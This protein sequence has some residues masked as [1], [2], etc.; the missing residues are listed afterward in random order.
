MQGDENNLE[1]SRDG[2]IL[3]VIAGRGSDRQIYTRAL[4][5]R[6]FR[7]VP[8][9]AGLEDLSLAVSPD[10][11]WV[12]FYRAGA[13][14]KTRVDGGA[15]VALFRGPNVYQAHWG[16][17]GFLYFAAGAES[18][19]LRLPEAG[20]EAE[21]LT[22]L[23][24]DK[25]E[26][27]HACPILVPGG[28]AVLFRVSVGS[29]A[30]GHLAAVNLA[31]RERRD[32]GLEADSPLHVSPTHLVYWLRGEVLA[33]PFDQ[34]ELRSTGPSV[35]VLTDVES[36]FQGRNAILAV[37]ASGTLAYL[38]R[39]GIHERRLVWKGTTGAVEPVGIPKSD[40]GQLA[41]SPDGTTAAL[42]RDSRSAG[43]IVA[44][45]LRR[46]VADP[47]TADA[48]DNRFPVF[49][50][51]GRQLAYTSSR[52]GQ[53]NLFAIDLD[54]DLPPRRLRASSLI[55]NA[56]SWSRDGFLAYAEVTPTE[57]SN[58]WALTSADGE[59]SPVPIANTEAVEM[60]AAFSPDGRWI[61]YLSD[62]SGE[63]EVYVARFDAASRSV[64]RAER[65][66]VD[67]GWR[68]VFSHDGKEL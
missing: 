67:G 56:V 54:S 44:L 55:H 14:W 24:A 65:A 13:L 68:P 63:F 11:A 57:D 15:P 31:S 46:G 53:Y 39:R 34:G 4:G 5:E 3:Y 16:E 38:P 35:P 7:P 51:S 59:R 40:Y 52:E 42:V 30:T 50:P 41:L 32:L 2:R 25:G 28:A 61:A 66:S 20:G 10:G 18:G 12:A 6:S 19:V 29:Y 9:T 22:E 45:D 33:A 43:D 36:D 62:K 17:D 21:Q 58:L 26:V 37:S 64:G 47:V 49:S 27:F 48:F 23:D 60:S 1:I 8:G